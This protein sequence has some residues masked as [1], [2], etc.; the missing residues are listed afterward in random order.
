MS[1][2]GDAGNRKEAT[3]AAEKPIDPCRGEE[4]RPSRKPFVVE[5]PEA[6]YLAVSGR[7]APGSPDFAARVGAL[8]AV[9]YTVKMSRKFSKRRDYKIGKLEA[10]WWTEENQA[11]F[12][13]V[14][15]DRWRWKLLI[16]T[17]E[18]V[19]PEEVDRSIAVLLEKGKGPEVKEVHRETLAEGACVQM[20]HVGP[21]DRE[22]ETIRE[23][24]AHAEGKGLAFH[25][26]HH[27]IYLSDPR[28]VPPER[29]KTILREPVRP[30]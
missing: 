11:N 26:V 7:G 3:V 2:S 16:R 14:P 19:G 15:K 24:R 12:A 4:Y 20:L 9:A 6:A 27:E 29:L 8:Y 23:M 28:R 22:E 17:P 18:F 21:Y 10:Q 25:G 5:V 13:E 1:R 30:R